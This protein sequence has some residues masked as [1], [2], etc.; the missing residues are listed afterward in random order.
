M[1][2]RAVF[3][4][5]V[6][7]ALGAG[8]A[9]WWST[10]PGPAPPVPSL[11]SAPKERDPAPE[12]PP[13]VAGRVVDRAPRGD[14]RGVRG[15]A[16]EARCGGD[17]PVRTLSGPGGAFAFAELPAGPCELSASAA[18]YVS[19]G[20]ATGGPAVVRVDPE[21][22]VRDVHLRLHLA[23]AVTGR[24]EDARGP[25]A[26]AAVSVLHLEVADEPGPFT[27][28]TD[29]RTDR[30]GRF[31]LDELLPGRIQ[32]MAEHERGYGESEPVL[33]EPGGSHTDLLVRLEPDDAEVAA[34]P[35]APPPAPLPPADPTKGALV[36]RVVDERGEPVGAFRV[37]VERVDGDRGPRRFGRFAMG[38]VPAEDIRSRRGA[39][40]VESLEPGVYAVHVGGAGFAPIR[41]E[42]HVVQA[43]QDTDAGVFTLLAEASVSGRVVDGET[44]EPIAGAHVS[45]EGPDARFAAGRPDSGPGR[46][47]SW[48]GAAV[49]GPDGRFVLRS[50][51]IRRLTLRVLAR[52]YVTRLVSGVEPL[53]AR[54]LQ[55]GAIDL[56]PVS[57]AD[58]GA[59]HRTFEYAG[60]GAVLEMSE[61]GLAFG[62]VFDG[63][64]A[65]SA[66]LEAGTR[67]RAIDGRPT[68]EMTLMEALELIRGEAGSP[69]ELEVSA[70][71][72][73][74]VRVVR[75]DRAVVRSP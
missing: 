36:G 14:G 34:V 65:A 52:G 11:A 60:V 25:V 59:S 24:V 75:L 4:I 29:V 19:G 26:G 63:A 9:F 71:G 21:A 23:A 27:V 12:A 43:G 49:S 16:V 66:G 40:R 57:E 54:E 48:A 62:P 30:Q 18:G 2:R 1:S 7:L 41:T 39:F 20:P 64:P 5:S 35:T 3:A 32:V 55:L 33:L 68:S 10:D 6:V 69:V 44:G 73:T 58:G 46:A 70:P 28:S 53:S 31:R 56:G 45:A 51:P 67:I 47:G 42:G 37:S 15:A 13:A 61:E 50:V 74:T 38:S 17:P 72:S 22:P 8:L